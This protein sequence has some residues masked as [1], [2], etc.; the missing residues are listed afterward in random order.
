MSDKKAESENVTWISSQRLVGLRHKANNIPLYSG[1]IRAKQG[2]AFVS[3]FKGRGMEFDESRIYLPGDDIRNMDW[4]VTAR[5]GIAHTKVYQEERERPVLLWLDLNPSMF[6]ATREAYKSVIATQA[7]ALLAWCVS[8]H[9]DRVGALIFAGDEHIE[10][11]P[12]RGKSAV[13]DFIGRTVNHSAWNNTNGT[14]RNMELAMARLRKVA[15]PGSLVFLLSDFREM[16]DKT[17]SH[18][19]NI[20]RHNDIVLI[21]VSDPIERELPKSGFYKVSDGVNEIS[22]NSADK[23]TRERYKQRYENHHESLKK[24]CRQHRMNLLNISTDEHV[25]E[26]LQKGLGKQ[27]QTRR[28]A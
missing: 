15:H 9:N 14:V 12:R 11:K 27:T 3:S 5:T 26:S 22:L 6:F 17:K 23:K 10:I 21:H 13:L 7:A 18:L 19:A 4:R 20:A 25:L 16:N 24:L 1:K 8:G 28:S 2:G